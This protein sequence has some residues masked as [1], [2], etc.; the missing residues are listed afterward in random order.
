MTNAVAD[1][2][3]VSLFTEEI[4]R[5]Q[6]LVAAEVT[7]KRRYAEENT[8]RKHNYGQIFSVLLLY[9]FLIIEVDRSYVLTDD[10]P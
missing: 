10:K 8:R 6:E 2:T 4:A 3:S 7:K 5:L 9:S 1:E